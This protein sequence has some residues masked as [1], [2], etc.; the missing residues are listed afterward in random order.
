MYF[1]NIILENILSSSKLVIFD[2]NGLII[3]D[4]GVQLYAVNKSLELFGITIHEKYWIEECVGH[5]PIEFYETILRINN[6]EH[7]KKI[8]NELIERKTLN[9]TEIIKDEVKEI[10]RPGINEIIDYLLLDKKIDLAIATS[11]SRNEFELISENSNLNMNSRFKYI[12]TGDH[13]KKGKPDPEMYQ[14]IL[15]KAQIDKFF[16]LVFEDTSPGVNSA[17]NAGIKCFAVPNKFTINQNFSNA[18]HVLDNLTP[19]AQII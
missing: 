18:I 10:V 13:V 15:Q 3:D 7:S 19:D 2:M 11:S 17:H 16:C 4:E 14:I 12:V 5:R 9:Y 1:K 8:I 6:K